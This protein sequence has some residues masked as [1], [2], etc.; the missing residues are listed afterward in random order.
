MRKAFFVLMFV[1]VSAGVFAEGIVVNT[2]AGRYLVSYFYE[3]KNQGQKEADDMVKWGGKRSIPSA[4]HWE[5]INYVLRIYQPTI[6]DT[7][8]I[9]MT[10]GWYR[11]TYAFDFV[12]EYTSATKYNYWFF[13]SPN[14]TGLFD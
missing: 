13:E 10:P 2:S 5:C 8:T 7:F 9:T 4:I 6:G 12:C 1:L 11:S 3:G 14:P